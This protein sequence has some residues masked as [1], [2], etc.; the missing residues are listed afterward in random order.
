MF[1]LA[2]KLDTIMDICG[3][4]TRCEAR[5]TGYWPSSFFCVFMDRDG[6]EDHELA[7]K[8]RGQ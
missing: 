5:M 8:E 7:K 3:F 1:S 6:V 4:L 2:L